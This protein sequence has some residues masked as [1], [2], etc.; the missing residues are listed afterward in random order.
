MRWRFDPM[1]A[2]RVHEIAA[3]PARFNRARNSRHLDATVTKMEREVDAWV[4]V[5]AEIRLRL[6]DRGLC[7]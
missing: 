7:E 6:W 1:A 2:V 5:G 4:G 3:G